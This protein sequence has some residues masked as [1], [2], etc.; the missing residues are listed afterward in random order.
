MI[1]QVNRM[2]S[3]RIIRMASEIKFKGK[4][5]MSQNKMVQPGNRRP[6]ENWKDLE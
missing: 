5:L 4:R 2:H 3:T 6:Q 1:Y